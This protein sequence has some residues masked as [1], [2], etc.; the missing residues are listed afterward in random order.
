MESSINFELK[1]AGGNHI[2]NI[3]FAVGWQIT[4]DI[5]YYIIIFQFMYTAAKC[6]FKNKLNCD[7]KL[8]MRK[9]VIA[10]FL[11]IFRTDTKI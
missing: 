6:F 8:D 5:I 11:F 7:H 4:S 9:T 10:T 2:I 3:Q 1:N